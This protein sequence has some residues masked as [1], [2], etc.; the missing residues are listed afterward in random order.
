[1][2]G[3]VYR[4]VLVPEIPNV[5]CIISYYWILIRVVISFDPDSTSHIQSLDNL[6]YTLIPRHIGR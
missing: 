2:L 4:S 5:Q 3:T 6:N 1:M